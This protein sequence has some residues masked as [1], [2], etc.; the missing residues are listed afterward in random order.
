MTKD[1][2]RYGKCP[3]CGKRYYFLRAQW[4]FN[5]QPIKELSQTQCNHC[6]ARLYIANGAFYGS[7]S[8]RAECAAFGSCSR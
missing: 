5:G 6:R 2:W 7:D 4:T 1:K 8:I 3:K